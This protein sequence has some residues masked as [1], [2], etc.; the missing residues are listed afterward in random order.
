MI[1]TSERPE[2]GLDPRFVIELRGKS[3]PLYAGVLDMAT[4]SGLKELST[5]LIQIPTADNGNV[6][7]VSATATFDDGRLF[8]DIGDAS[9]ANVGKHIATALIRM[10][11]TRA[12]GRVLRDAMNIGQALAEEIHDDEPTPG[13][14]SARPAE[15]TTTRRDAPPAPPVHV[16]DASARPAKPQLSRAQAAE[17]YRS[18]LERAAALGALRFHSQAFNLLREFDPMT[19]SEADLVTRA[20]EL[21]GL[22]EKLEREAEPA[23]EADL[24]AD[25]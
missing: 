20:R 10:A 4:R 2:A 1:E 5:K 19:G 21:K 17:K 23:E 9:P 3:V 25:E 6:A 16:S 13:Q 15:W 12:K 14:Q 18:W 7:I 24:F 11:S 8:E 22:V